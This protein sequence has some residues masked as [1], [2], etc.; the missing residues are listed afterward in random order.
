[1]GEAPE[2]VIM[3]ALKSANLIGDGFYRVDIKQ[4]DNHCYVIKVNDNPNVDAAT[5]MVNSRT[6]STV[7]L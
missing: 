4:M 7:L 1:V 3:P 2:E 6:R 5:K